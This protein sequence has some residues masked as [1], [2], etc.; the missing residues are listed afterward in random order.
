MKDVNHSAATIESSSFQQSSS[1][2]APFSFNQSTSS[3]IAGPPTATGSNDLKSQ[4]GYAQSNI[5][6]KPQTTTEY[7][8]QYG[9]NQTQNY[10]GQAPYSYTQQF[11]QAVQSPISKSYGQ[12]Y[13][14]VGG[15]QSAQGLNSQS[16]Y[17]GNQY[18]GYANYTYGQTLPVPTQYN[19]LY[20]RNVYSEYGPSRVVQ[21]IEGEPN[22]RYQ[23][24]EPRMISQKTWEGGMRQ[25]GERQL[26]HERISGVQN[27]LTIA[28]PAVESKKKE[29]YIEYIKEI[30]VPVNKY[31]DVKYDVVVD[32][33]IER[34]FEK[35]KITEVMVERPVEK[36]VE[37]PVQQIVEIPVEK[38][39][40]R[41]VEQTRY[42]EKPYERV[43]ER[44]YEVVKENLIYRDKIIDIDERDLH[45]YPSAERL[46]TKVNYQR[47][48]NF[49]EKPVYIDNVIERERLIP[50]EKIIDLPREKI[51]ERRIP[52][53]IDRPVPVETTITKEIE[54]PVEVPVYKPVNVIVEQERLYENIITKP[55]PIERIVEVDVPV[56]VEHVVERPV[57]VENLI[58]KRIQN[59]V[60]VPVPKEELVEIPV[61]VFNETRVPVEAVFAR[62]VE[63]VI[64]APK[65]FIKQ[66]A[67]PLE[68]QVDRMVPVP[69]DIDVPI[70]VNN[71]REKPMERVVKRP[72]YIER[73]VERPKEVEKLVDVPYENIREVV[74]VVEKVVEQP[75]YYDA[76]IEKEVEVI[77][78]KIVEVPVEKIIEVPVEIRVEVPVY[79]EINQEHDLILE[80]ETLTFTEDP[81]VLESVEEVADAQLQA[82]IE[83]R[84]QAISQERA[85]GQRLRGEFEALRAKLDTMRRG[86]NTN[87][88]EMNI[89]L[90]G[91][92][93]EL[94][95]KVRNA[96]GENRLRA[97]KGGSKRVTEAIINADP[98]M[99]G[100]Q[101]KLDRALHENQRLVSEVK[102]KGD[103]VRKSV[104]RGVY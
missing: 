16:V 7:P 75:V 77:V 31:V 71:Y 85:Q 24:L 13:N 95:S 50:R 89:Q 1:R 88:Q 4:Q 79:N 53:T 81:H 46:Q 48:Q 67:V 49:V 36:I 99:E 63:R 28:Q 102:A 2:A 84:T 82:E 104:G 14:Q 47:T 51:V 54:V 62:P 91:Q 37:V 58:E 59:I 55:V 34:V 12:T 43:V 83:S 5:S 23:N 73:L 100:L 32:V 76:I 80:T 29:K 40:E 26:S 45:R 78:E 18:P 6:A 17:Y 103:A 39:I 90:L 20:Q 64:R 94:S 68:Q 33:P 41:P 74:K 87:D 22:V 61:E 30:P 27:T 25:I 38:I 21:T 10:T 93:M 56:M 60:E 15:I 65:P 35:E 98:R 57:I 101:A 69:V 19:E 42:V 70:K 3:K 52:V 72:V 8:T 86:I 96:E 97:A 9:Q 66:V 92:Y 11:S 44:P